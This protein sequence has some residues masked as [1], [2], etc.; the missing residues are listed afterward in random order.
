VVLPIGTKLGTYCVTGVVATGGMGE[1]YR[2][3]DERLR[4]E[5]A[6]KVLP[7]RIFDRADW[8]ARFQREARIVSGLNHPH[9]LTVHDIG[10]VHLP[11]HFD[12]T[13]FIV[14]EFV[15]GIT[16]RE[17][18]AESGGL[19]DRRMLEYMAQVADALKKAHSAGIVHRDLKPENIMF[20]RDGYAKVLDFGLAKTYTP[21]APDGAIFDTQ[22]GI[23]M[24][25][26]GY[27]SPEQIRAKHVDHR[28]DIFSF[29]CL[30][31][32]LLTGELPFNGGD[33]AATLHRITTAKAPALPATVDPALRQIVRRCLEKNPAR[34]FQNMGEVADGLRAVAART[35]SG[36]HRAPSPP[37]AP[38]PRSTG[39]NRIVAVLPFTNSSGDPEMEYLSDGITESIIY[40]L[41]QVRKRLRVVARNTVFAYKNRQVTPAQLAAELGATVVI[42][43][44]VQRLGASI[45]VAA[46]MVSTSDGSQLWGAR[47]Q[48]PFS[49]IFEV[50]EQIATSISEQLRL[51][52]TVTERRKLVH[53]PTR[54]S[55]AYE[56]YLKGRFLMNRRTT[57]SF[58]QA[59][60]LFQEA[61][62]I[63]PNYALAWAALAEAHALRRWRV[64]TNGAEIGALAA[65]AARTAIALDP[66]LASPHATL[67]YLA[68]QEWEWN[69]AER[70]YRTAIALDPDYATAHHWYSHL[71]VYMGRLGEAQLEARAAVDIEPLS[72]VFNISYAGTLYIG[73][74]HDE[75]EH[76]CRNMLELEPR[77][78]FAQWMLS[79][80]LLARGRFDDAVSLLRATLEQCGRYPE[81]LGTLGYAHARLGDREEALRLAAEL[82][83]RDHVRLA[84]VYVGL[85]DF[86]EAL[87][88]AEQL[89]R[90]RGEISMVLA[91]AQFATLREDPRYDAMLKRVAFPRATAI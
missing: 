14:T 39:R 27:M 18:M 51:R 60:T 24:G 65:D 67:A 35:A 61:V 74:R 31:F 75:A 21:D 71:L 87:K 69:R 20:T 9:I 37:T 73:G 90:A 13:H 54:R 1:V 64:T 44:R 63:D 5:V 8:L 34:R 45:L 43:G 6:L 12:P 19:D 84:E 42:T 33:L 59:V 55:E 88:H 83:P 89:F 62:T 38:R 52:L 2:A 40:A 68:F 50:Q 76:V 22:Q 80:V 36:V 72:L 25:T 48:R 10:E 47:F 28:A 15:D 26:V 57:E 46:D 79:L 41:T 17:A 32:E 29:G 82:D 4:R 86:E 77:F 91:A 78:Y 70:E 56:V 85:D 53:A 23:A 81:L 49:D 30:L 7:P 16:M 58:T 3:H 11:G 66:A